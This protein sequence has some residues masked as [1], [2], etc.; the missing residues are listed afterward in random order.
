MKKQIKSHSSQA[1]TSYRDFLMVGSAQLLLDFV[2][3]LIILLSFN[4]PAVWANLT[5]GY[6]IISS[7]SLNVYLSEHAPWLYNFFHSSV[8]SRAISMLLWL[9][10]GCITYLIIWFVGSF[11]T[12]LRNDVV[13][14]SY[15][16]PG[17]YDKTGFWLSV[18]SR[19]VMFVCL[20]VLLLV[21]IYAAFSLLFELSVGS[22][23]AIINFV[24][25]FSL[26]YMVG[27]LVTSLVAVHLFF[28]LTR[29]IARN[30][31]VIYNDL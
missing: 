10:I 31:K 4:I 8:A 17:A 26:V 27:S 14:D 1:E 2:I 29:L 28:I 15:Q 12:S 16:H 24:P 6:E 19:K 9:F 30:W 3:G 20:F 7:P 25:R 5:S 18:L 22:Y 13:A 21:Y 23:E 11:L